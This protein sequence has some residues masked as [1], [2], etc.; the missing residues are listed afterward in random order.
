MDTTLTTEYAPTDRLRPHPDNPRRGDVAAIKQ[1]LELNGQYRPIVVHRPTMEAPA[2]ASVKRGAD[3]PP[4]C[5]HG[6][7]RF[8]GADPRRGKTKWRCPTGKCWPAS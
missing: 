3:K 2:G 7:W 5:E 8:A 1:S 6:E 4:T